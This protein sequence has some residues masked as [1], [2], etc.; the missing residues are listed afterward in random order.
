[1]YQVCCL[2][3]EG[4]VPECRGQPVYQEGGALVRVQAHRE[5]QEGRGESSTGQDVQVQ[6]WRC[7]Q[8]VRTPCG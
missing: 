2:P 3:G 7:Q 1:M 4:E 5:D 8:S 6:T